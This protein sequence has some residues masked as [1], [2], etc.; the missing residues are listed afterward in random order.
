[1]KAESQSCDKCIPRRGGRKGEEKMGGGWGR[2]EREREERER[3]R[4]DGKKKRGRGRKTR[5]EEKG[6]QIMMWSREFKMR[7]S[8]RGGWQEEG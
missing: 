8:R 6:K 7:E 2:G 4:K 5:R 3:G 1:M